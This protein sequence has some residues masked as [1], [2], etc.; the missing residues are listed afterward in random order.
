MKIKKNGA[1]EFPRSS[2]PSIS[3]WSDL[4]ALS[5]LLAAVIVVAVPAEKTDKGKTGTDGYPS[6]AKIKSTE[7]I[8]HRTPSKKGLSRND[9]FR[10]KEELFGA[11]LSSASGDFRA[12][13]TDPFLI[14]NEADSMKPEMA[15][16]GVQASRTPLFC[17][18]VQNIG[19]KLSGQGNF[20]Q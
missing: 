8:K 11:S 13:A 1:R 20:L 12:E 17:R 5:G 16:V 3:V 2:V 7:F 10:S 18:Q 14:S 9:T 15:D 6:D 19:Q 4:E